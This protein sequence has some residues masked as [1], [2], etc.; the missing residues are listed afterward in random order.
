MATVE[1]QS[2]EGDD[3]TRVAMLM[4]CMCRGA[5]SLE[6]VFGTGLCNA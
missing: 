5:H 3:K 1:L 6:D 2:A 4:C